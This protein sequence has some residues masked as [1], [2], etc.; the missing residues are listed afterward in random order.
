MTGRDRMVVIALAALAIVALAWIEV[1]SPERKRASSVESKVASAEVA[2][3]DARGKLAS[4]KEDEKRFSAAYSSVVSL[5]EAVPAAE[6]VSSLVYAVDRAAGKAKVQFQSISAGGGSTARAT[7][8]APAT[9]AGAGFQQLPFTFTFV[10]S[11][12]DLY[13]MM[14][15]L[16]SFTVT[17]ANGDVKVSGRLLTVNGLSLAAASG[18]TASGS[19]TGTVTATAYV[20]PAGETLTAGA[21]TSGPAGAATSTSATGTGAS[22]P[23][24]A[25]V[26]VGP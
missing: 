3:S 5:G 12:F 23:A 7:P 19:L 10:G 17:T 26:K 11:F 21:T 1:V 20:L 15:R 2:L 22:A 4:A 24:P 14:Q 25:V 8:T 16:Q 9:T 18:S 6:E 13:H